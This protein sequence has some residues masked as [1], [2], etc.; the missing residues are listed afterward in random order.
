VALLS[1]A[2]DLAKPAKKGAAK[3]LTLPAADVEAALAGALREWD[4]PGARDAIVALHGLAR[5]FLSAD[6]AKRFEGG[7]PHLVRALAGI[8][9][10]L[11]GSGTP[12]GPS[13]L[14][15]LGD[16]GGRAIA[17][18]IAA[19]LVS[20][21][22]AF[23]DRGQADQG[24]VMLLGTLLVCSVRRTAPPAEAIDLAAKHRSKIAWALSLFAEVTAAE[25]A[26]RPRV[27]AFAPRAC[28]RSAAST[29]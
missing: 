3:A 8:G 16:G 5:F 1:D 17:G 26:G 7:G 28:A 24:D 11:R 6:P 23:Y 13:I 25:T 9:E 2:M 15:A 4:E 12:A 22:K 18:D 10:L 21:A 19:A 27:A 29:T 14:D 20:Y